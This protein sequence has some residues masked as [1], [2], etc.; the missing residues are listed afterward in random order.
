MGE[1]RSPESI[2]ALGVLAGPT[3]DEPPEEMQAIAQAAARGTLA[4]L[5]GE[6]YT[7]V[8]KPATVRDV[9]ARA[10]WELRR[11]GWRLDHT[12]DMYLSRWRRYTLRPPG[13]VRGRSVRDVVVEVPPKGWR[14]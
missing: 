3:G 7:I 13:V 14:P 8:P 10:M 1:R 5:A 12:A 2:I 6:G 9:V 4:L 11:L